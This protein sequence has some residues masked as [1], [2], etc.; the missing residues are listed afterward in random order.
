M[1]EVIEEPAPVPV[2]D[3]LQSNSMAVD[4]DAQTAEACVKQIEFYFSDSNL[5]YDRFMWTLHTKNDSHY[6]P[7]ATIASFK[8]MRGYLAKGVDWISDALRASH[9]LEV[10]AK[11]QNVRRKADV[12]PPVNVLDRSV[13]VKGFGEDE[14]GG[15]LQ[16]ELEKFFSKW[17]TIVAVRLRRDDD[18]K[19]K[20]SVFVE[21]SEQ[22]S[23]TAFLEAPESEK[24]WN[25]DSLLTYSK[26][27]YCLMK[28]KEKG[29]KGSVESLRHQPNLP[30]RPAGQ[31]RFDA[32]AL[33]AEQETNNKNKSAKQQTTPQV[34]VTLGSESMKVEANGTVLPEN[35]KYPPNSAIKFSGAG[36][37][38]AKFDE[39]K[40]TLKPI[41]N[42]N[43]YIELQ[44]G[45][46]EGFI[47]FSSTVTEE[48]LA[49]IKKA[50]PSIGGSEVT[51]SIAP[52]ENVREIQ[53]K[54]IQTAAKLNAENAKGKSSKGGKGGQQKGGNKRNTGAGAK[55]SKPQAMQLDA[56][57]KVASAGNET[58]ATGTESVPPTPTT[59]TKRKM[60]EAEES[61]STGGKKAKLDSGT[62][63]SS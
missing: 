2:S 10:D 8:R 39:I 20:G 41:S 48:M 40:K 57:P 30:S 54:R 14:K 18:K 36:P 31:R 42:T 24:R 19:F 7:I 32:F 12:K 52:D 33:M 3:A 37:N 61:D 6:V 53:T 60:D 34:V 46:S 1:S 28:M 56:P 45:A 4:D 5:P 26:E 43:V 35:I 51:Y 38:K 23:A 11:G 15:D 25:G 22:V 44:Q 50:V 13:Y 16:K 29:I 58:K 21:F 55:G 63:A 9:L 47:A 62:E 49:K 17:G 27:N 59:A